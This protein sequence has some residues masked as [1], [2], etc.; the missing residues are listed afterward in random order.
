MLGN[1]EEMEAQRAEALSLKE[2]CSFPRH[3]EFRAWHAER[4]R[5]G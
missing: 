5:P 1:C 3:D 2:E 4:G